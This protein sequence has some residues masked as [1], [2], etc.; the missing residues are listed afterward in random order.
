MSDIPLR[1]PKVKSPFKRQENNNNEY[2]VYDEVNDGYDWVFENDEVTC[3]EKLDGTNCAIRIGQD[4]HSIRPVEAYTRH[5]TKPFQIAK[6]YSGRGAHRKIVRA[7]QNSMK[8]GYLRSLD[9]GVHYGEAVG[10]AFQ[11][12]PHELEENLF[13]PFKWLFDKCAYKSWGKYPKDFDTISGWFEEDL[14]SL[15]YSRMH[16]CSL[17][18]ATV[19]NGAFCEGVVFVHPD[20]AA[21]G[22]REE[23]IVTEE[24]TLSSGMYRKVHP[25]LAKLRRD[26]FH[27]FDG[28]RH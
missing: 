26:M 16:G 28:E 5:G 4:A 24:E 17:D 10:P 20:A 25:H 8:R 18:D 15:F 1:F 13:I 22:Y 7:V 9:A 14:F 19:S 21:G 23:T 27:W 3:V 12:N 11:G 2:V 6:P